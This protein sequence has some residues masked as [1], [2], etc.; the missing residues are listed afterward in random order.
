MELSEHATRL[1]RLVAEQRYEEARPA[2]ADYGRA[3]EQALGRAPPGDPGVL[4]M[5]REGR[6]LLENARRSALA[7]R[8]H[9]AA[10]RARL[11]RLHRY[12]NSKSPPLPT[13]ELMG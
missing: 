6:Q 4:Q 13:W 8:A 11:P 5:V 7:G 9:A 2:L 10:R 1:R 12:Y 3:L